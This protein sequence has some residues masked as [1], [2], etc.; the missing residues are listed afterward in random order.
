MAN[1]GSSVSTAFRFVRA[2]VSSVRSLAWRR[3]LL[4][5]QRGWLVLAVTLWGLGRLRKAAGRTPELVSSERLKPGETIQ[6]TALERHGG[7][8]SPSRNAV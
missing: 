8:S 2:P 4:D 1:T 3:G 5:G 7:T 6:I